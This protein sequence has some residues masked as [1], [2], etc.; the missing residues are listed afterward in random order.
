MYYSDRFLQ[1]RNLTHPY[2][3]QKEHCFYFQCRLLKNY[4]LI[5]RKIYLQRNYRNPEWL[6]C[7][8]MCKLLS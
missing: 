3:L 5:K 6:Q 7:S 4:I 2:S 1:R 8:G